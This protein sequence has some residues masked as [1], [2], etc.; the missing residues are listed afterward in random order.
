VI[1]QQAEEVTSENRFD[2]SLGSIAETICDASGREH[3]SL[4]T[5][6]VLGHV[7][8]LQ[9]CFSDFSQQS[10]LDLI[11]QTNYLRAR[12]DVW[13]GLQQRHILPYTGFNTTEERHLT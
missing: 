10:R 7:H 5:P 4:H 1:F 13:R 12:S 9:I 11:L 2:D 6:T 3:S 8:L